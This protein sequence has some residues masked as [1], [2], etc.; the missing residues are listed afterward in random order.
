[1]INAVEVF[2]YF[3]QGQL[4]YLRV[5][6][7]KT[8]VNVITTKAIRTTKSIH[9]ILNG[10][11]QQPAELCKGYQVP[12]EQAH[13]RHQSLRHFY[14]SHKTQIYKLYCLPRVHLLCFFYYNTTS[15]TAPH[16]TVYSLYVLISHSL[17][18][19]LCSHQDSQHSIVS[20]LC[21]LILC[22]RSSALCSL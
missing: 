5:R 2:Y 11:I 15:D 13:L 1:M 9:F 19:A 6:P 12:T 10:L 7:T 18:S 21:I 8:T 3:V 17:L 14:I 20:I 22:G 4:S 16:S